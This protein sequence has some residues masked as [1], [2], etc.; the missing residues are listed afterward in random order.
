MSSLAPNT[1][2]DCYV[3]AKPNL[4]S[5]GICSTEPATPVATRQGAPTL[6]SA[7]RDSPTAI[8]ITI[9]AN[10]ASD[11][12][13]TT[14]TYMVQCL[15]SA[16]AAATAGACSPNFGST[17]VT[18]AQLSSGYTIPVTTGNETPTLYDWACSQGLRGRSDDIRLL[19]GASVNCFSAGGYS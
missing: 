2:D 3:V 14:L 17:V 10:A 18:D 7:T 8:T 4:G 15:S 13:A 6:V 11:G 9:T 5:T 12:G 16:Q 19:L 1:N